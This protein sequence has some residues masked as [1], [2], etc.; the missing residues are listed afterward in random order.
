MVARFRDLADP[1]LVGGFVAIQAR[2][3]DTGKFRVNLR[4]IDCDSGERVIANSYFL[5]VGEDGSLASNPE[6]KR[7]VC[8]EEKRSGET[9]DGR[10]QGV[11]V[12]G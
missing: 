3:I 1:S 8:D 10:D 6:F 7:R 12:V 5:T 4:D 11:G 9:E 2:K